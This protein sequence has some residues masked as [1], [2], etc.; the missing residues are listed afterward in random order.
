MLAIL[1]TDTVADSAA[2]SAP[3]LARLCRGPTQQTRALDT[4]E[5]LRRTPAEHWLAS[6]YGLAPAVNPAAYARLNEAPQTPVPAEAITARPVH[7]RATMDHLVLH[8]PEGLMITR[9]E[10]EALAA[11]ARQHF[12]GD[13]IGWECLSATC[14]AVTFG[15]SLRAL[16]LASA[17]AAHG[18]NVDLYMP[19]GDDGR[20]ARAVLNEL[21]MLWHDHPVNHER[22]ARGLPA[23]NSLWF[24]GACPAVHQSPF[25][26]V[27][28]SDDTLAGLARA[29]GATLAPA[30]SGARAMAPALR[31]ALGTGEVLW[32]PGPDQ[33]DAL[34]AVLSVGGWPRGSRLVRLGPASWQVH[35][36]DAR[37]GPMDWL[38]RWFGRG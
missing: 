38:R 27:F 37:P 14:W 24:E 9:D 25:A 11:T 33:T 8:S 7:L 36:I 3:A 6:A 4:P 16:E 32:M 21:Q 10:S 31:Q 23:V 22:E 17:R 29:T 19:A 35:A 12:G 2:T 1:L 26:A 13:G 5:A 15:E 20:R 18:R 34:D 30:P 28:G